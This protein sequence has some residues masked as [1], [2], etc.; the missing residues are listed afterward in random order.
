MAKAI[1]TLF[2]V[3]II[4]M[5]IAYPGIG[6]WDKVPIISQSVHAALDPTAGKLLNWNV[7]YG[8]IIFTAILSLALTLMQKYT[9][10]QETLREIKKEQKLLQQEMKNYKDNPEKLMDLQKKQLAIIPKT[11]EITLRPIM[12]TSIPIILFFRWF[13]DYF[14]EF[15]VKVLGMHWMFAYIIFSMILTTVFRK[16]LKVA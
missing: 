7:T 9:T 13:S 12:Y 14:L 15:P 6:L 2:L 4:G 10:D 16:V 11:F 8:L 3:M 5:V 1:R